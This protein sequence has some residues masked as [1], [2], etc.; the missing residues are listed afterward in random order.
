[1]VRQND[2][3]APQRARRPRTLVLIAGVTV[4]LL[5]GWTAFLGIGAIEGWLRRPIA[6]RGDAPAFAETARAVMER[7]NAGN[8]AFALLD[9]GRVVAEHFASKGAAVDRDSLFQVASLSKWVTAWGV[10]KLAE[11]KRIDLDAPVSTYLARWRLPDGE[12]D[13]AQV[14]VRRLLSHT[15]GL[16]DGLGYGGFPPGEPIQPLV[17]SLTLAID[18]SPGADG[19]V[20][21]G[22]P[23]GE[24]FEYSGGGYALL[25][26][27]VEEVSGEPFS[28]YMKRAVLDPLG[29]ERSTYLLPDNVANVAEFFDTD[30]SK[31][32]HYRFSAPAAASLYTSA[33]DMSRF[34]QAHV[35]GENSEPPG[36]GV[37]TPKS[38]E[39]MRRPHADQ[40]GA[41]IWGMGTILYAPNDAGGFVIGHDGS[42]TPAINTS[43]RIDPASG[44]GIVVLETGHTRLATDIAGEWVFWNT[45][46]VD[47]FVV[48][49]DLRRALPVL[50]GGWL[51]LV[52]G[53]ILAGF[54]V[55]G[56]R[57][58]ASA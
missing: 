23:P 10:M 42:N 21:V 46:N 26:L 24:S 9:G 47:L 36:R 45:G 50:V 28:T 54:V 3:I 57:R 8:I 19:R 53:A 31:A 32:I 12:F 41:E 11:E 49:A 27:L 55:V 48:L 29:M 56:G 14:T 35:A 58:R 1:M 4:V 7:E 15:A 16:T 52:I 30:G 38:L 33:A 39:D 22:A 34:L 13:E 6:P 40:F 25:Q 20:R 18:A 2:V 44:D 5:V 37:L 43:A 51:A 17:D